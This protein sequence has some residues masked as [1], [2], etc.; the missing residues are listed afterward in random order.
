ME[1]GVLDAVGHGVAVALAAAETF[2]DEGL[3]RLLGAAERDPER[4]RDGTRRRDAAEGDVLERAIFA[5]DRA[6]R[7]GEEELG[8]GLQADHAFGAIE[9]AVLGEPL[10]GAVH[11]DA[12]GPAVER[13]VVG[14]A[15]ARGEERALVDAGGARERTRGEQGVRATA[16]SVAL[17][18]HHAS[19]AFVRGNSDREDARGRSSTFEYD[20]G[21]RALTF[22]CRQTVQTPWD[23][24]LGS[25]A[26]RVHGRIVRRDRSVRQGAECRDVGA[27]ERRDVA[28]L[29]GACALERTRR[30]GRVGG[31]EGRAR[32]TE[33]ECELP[34]H[35]DVPRR[36]RVATER[37]EDVGR[38]VRATDEATHPCQH[39]VREEGALGQLFGRGHADAA[40]RELFGLDGIV[41]AAG[42]RLERGELDDRRRT[43]VGACVSTVGFERGGRGCAPFEHRTPHVELRSDRGGRRALDPSSCAFGVEAYEVLARDQKCAVGVDRCRV[44][45]VAAIDVTTLRAGGITT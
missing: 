35:P 45:T 19:R 32:S 26:E 17:G 42:E 13:D 10:S 37:R 5:A 27:H 41:G 36:R 20:P 4:V 3:E 7:I 31:H 39:E 29:A 38:Q 24:V 9:A 12:E 11:G 14:E 33:R 22:D 43:S 34:R 16:V 15:V 21:D 40:A 44:H 8:V 23:G 18:E 25:S 6:A 30:L 1:R 28:E 2:A